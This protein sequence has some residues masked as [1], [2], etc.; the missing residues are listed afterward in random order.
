MTSV[1]KIGENSDQSSSNVW[2][3]DSNDSKTIVYLNNPDLIPNYGNYDR[4]VKVDVNNG[5]ID[6]LADSVGN[7][8][9][10]TPIREGEL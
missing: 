5:I 1:D 6:I 4:A 8:E 9:L 2:F 3:S 7:E 10:A